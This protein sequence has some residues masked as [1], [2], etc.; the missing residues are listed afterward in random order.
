M[1][2]QQIYSNNLNPAIPN[3]TQ[4]FTDIIGFF[5]DAPLITNDLEIDCFLQIY[6]NLGGREVARNLPLGKIEEQAILLNKTDTETIFS[7]PQE[8]VNSNHE[9]ALLFLSSDN[10][11]LEVYA[12]RKS[13][14]LADELTLINNKLDLI[15][16]NLDFVTLPTLPTPIT[17]EQGFFFIN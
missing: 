10:T 14:N 6:F 17:S 9:M 16:N 13:I 15:L 12:V 8:F 5:I 4:R 3:L 2:L 11:F 1:V 7:I